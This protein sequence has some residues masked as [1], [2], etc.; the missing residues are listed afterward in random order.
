V[1][2]SAGLL[3]PE[4]PWS[5]RQLPVWLFAAINYAIGFAVWTV[6]VYFAARASGGT[7]AGDAG[8]PHGKF[9]YAH[10]FIFAGMYMVIM[11]AGRWRSRAGR[12]RNAIFLGLVLL[13]AAAGGALV[14][15]TP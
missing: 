13:T 3:R 8:Y 7:R 4:P 12:G 5:A 1:R 6:P 11:L 14:A 15:V 2:E 9:S 10:A